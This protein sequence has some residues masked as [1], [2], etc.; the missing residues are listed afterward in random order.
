MVS[1]LLGRERVSRW[2][3]VCAWRV[4]MRGWWM[5]EGRKVN[6]R[7]VGKEEGK[8]RKRSEKRALS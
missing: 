3:G 1:G 2:V 8:R 6:A 5:G 4:E 7:K